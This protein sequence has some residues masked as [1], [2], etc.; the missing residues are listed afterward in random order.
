MDDETTLSPAASLVTQ[1]LAGTDVRME[2]V[3]ALQ[4]SIASGEYSVSSSA[5]AAKVL[6]ALMN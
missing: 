5:V 1:A 4:Q 2:K 6:N 3:A